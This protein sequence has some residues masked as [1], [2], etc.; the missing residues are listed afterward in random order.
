MYTAAEIERARRRQGI[1]QATKGEGRFLRE[2]EAV[3]RIDPVLYHNAVQ[4]NRRVYGVRDC[5]A[6]PEFLNDQLRRHPELRVRNVG[7]SVR[8]R[9]GDNRETREADAKGNGRLT[10]FGRTTF[11]KS[12]QQAG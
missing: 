2:G 12:Y 11:H 3:A 7:R 9:V 8:A 4:S 5:W 1:I 10:R 6:E